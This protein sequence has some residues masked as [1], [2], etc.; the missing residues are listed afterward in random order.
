MRRSVCGAIY[1]V[2]WPAR[3][4]RPD[5]G[6]GLSE[7]A[8]AHIRSLRDLTDRIDIFTCTPNND[9]LDALSANEA[10]YT[11]KPGIEY[12]VFFPDGGNVVLDTEAAAGNMIGVQWLDIRKSAWLAVQMIEADKRLQLVTPKEEGYWAVIVKVAE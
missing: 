12:A 7:I 8:Q 10:Y 9:L 6:L 1:L 3:F 4:H 11:A 5:A 2:A